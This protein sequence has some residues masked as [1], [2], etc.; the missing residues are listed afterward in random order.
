MKRS[1]RPEVVQPV[2]ATFHVN[3]DVRTQSA[4]FVS[5]KQVVEQ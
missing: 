5:G 3:E 1:T 4:I 2:F